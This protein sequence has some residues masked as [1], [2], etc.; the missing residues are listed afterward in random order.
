MKLWSRGLGR[1]ELTMDFRSY[2]VVKDPETGNVC[3][4]GNIKDPVNWEFRIVMEPEDIP[5][6]M[7]I[8][9][10]ISVL[11]LGV[12]NAHRYLSFLFGREKFDEGHEGLEEKVNT[13]YQQMMR[14][15]TR[16]SRNAHRTTH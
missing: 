15:S 11:T 9:F 13:A 1:T 6:F 3:I 8:L 5:G 14:R 7:K 10:N 12:K 4:I 2:K 16:Q